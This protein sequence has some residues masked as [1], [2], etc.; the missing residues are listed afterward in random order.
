MQ[1]T[2]QLSHVL[3]SIPG[4]RRLFGR[5]GFHE[6]VLGLDRPAAPVLAEL[7]ARG[8]E[9][10]LDLVD[11]YPELGPALLLCATE[12]KTAADID[13]YGRALNDVL[14]AARAA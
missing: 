7:S 14:R 3:T 8:I 10:G 6:F 11:Y 5:A 2:E 13:S 4:A 9:G 1:R 12:T